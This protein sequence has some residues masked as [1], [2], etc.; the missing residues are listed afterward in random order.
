VKYAKPLI[1]TAILIALMLAA[2]A[3]AWPRLGDQPIPVHFGLDG[4]PNGYAP[5]GEA[6]LAMPITALLLSVLFTILPP[7]MPAR[8]RLERS[9]APF[10][11]VWIATLILLLA[12]HLTLLAY[13][14]GF[15]VDVGR[16]TVIG[17]GALFAVI[18]NL[19]GKVRYNYMFGVRTPWTLSS[20]RV[21]DRTHRFAG[22]L[23]AIAGVLM[24]TAGLLSPWPMV[25]ALPFV[26]LVGAVGPALAAVVYSYFESRREERSL[27]G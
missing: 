20:E 13:A 12:V 8:A 19:L 9:W 26:V 15:P 2:S 3:W 18:G 1:A 21:W 25:E 16:V 23:M 27:Q 11:T 14:V 17:V 5:K 22:W 7:L 24:V 10:V 6:V 4:R